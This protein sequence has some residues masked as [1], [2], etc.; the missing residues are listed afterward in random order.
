MIV[1]FLRHWWVHRKRLNDEWKRGTRQG[2]SKSEFRRLQ[3]T[4]LSVIFFYFPFSI[5][6]FVEALKL[7]RI[8]FSWDR[9]HG[10]MWW[11]IVSI[12]LP[13]AT[14]GMWLGPILAFTCFFFIGATRNAR[15]FYLKCVVWICDHTP[16]RLVPSIRRSCREFT[17]RQ[18][19]QE[20]MLRGNISAIDGYIH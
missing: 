17:E 13:R 18:A 9:I 1:V 15:L 8:P 20:M 6:A 2:I 3:L 4:V 12:P 10:P 5:Y 19:A 11:V 7:H 16:L 14:I